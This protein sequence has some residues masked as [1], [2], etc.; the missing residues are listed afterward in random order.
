MKEIS[1][2]EDLL[3]RFLLGEA[4]ERERAEVED[5]LLRDVE[6]YERLLA[7]EGDLMDAYV[8]EALP[9]HERAQFEESFLTSARQRERVE[10]ARGLAEST[11]RLHQQE[12]ARPRIA[13][14]PAE[15]Q[16]RR[17]RLTFL[18]TPQPA[19]RY[20]LAAAALV[21]VAVAVW[22]A[23]ER[24][25]AR[26][27]LEP[28]QARTEG[29]VPQKPEQRPQE[30]EQNGGGVV[31]PQQEK[32]TSPSP[33]AGGATPETAAPARPLFATITLAP[34]SLRDG[35]AAGNL[36]LPRNTTHVR[37]RLE[38]EADSYRNY[39]ATISS[40]EGR[41]VW[42]GSARKNRQRD[43]QSVTLTLPA[44]SLEQGDYVVELSGTVAS[45]RSEPAAQYSFRVTRQD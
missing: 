34:G 21:V 38:L 4:S 43:A 44:A 3:N 12:S 20:A 9:A 8:R 11:T 2:T 16:G 33:E 22:L 29:V 10:F 42:A 39:R 40:P 28:Q 37:L 36:V 6:F 13:F 18:F 31:P 24:M 27:G 15:S 14:A 32:R 45:G 23:V 35:A 41:R 19:L 1:E 17:G 26:P 7:A 30:R 5:R 25:R